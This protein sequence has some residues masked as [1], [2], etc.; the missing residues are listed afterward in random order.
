MHDCWGDRYNPV[1][2]WTVTTVG[3]D[4][5]KFTVKFTCEVKCERDQHSARFHRHREIPFPGVTTKVPRSSHVPSLSRTG[6]RAS[7]SASLTLIQSALPLT[8]C[9]PAAAASA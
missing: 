5:Y 6:R 7:I 2:A 4:R 9:H 8:S 3:Y 1:G